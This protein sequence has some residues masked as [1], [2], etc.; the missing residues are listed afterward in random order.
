MYTFWDVKLLL[1]A[2][3]L[4]KWSSSTSKRHRIAGK[5][6]F[7]VKCLPCKL[8]DLNLHPLDPYKNLAPCSLSTG[9]VKIRGSLKVASTFLWSCRVSKLQVQWETL[10]Q[11]V[12]AKQMAQ[13]TSV[14][15]LIYSAYISQVD[16]EDCVILAFKN[17]ETTEIPWGKLAKWTSWKAMKS[18][19][20]VN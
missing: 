14:C 13:W 9:K 6:A 3:H 8:D 20:S 5:V 2:K 11:V 16:V 15:L 4:H 7:L 17:T 12:W 10:P 19:D 1:A 18:P